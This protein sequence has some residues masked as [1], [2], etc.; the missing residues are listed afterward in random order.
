MRGLVWFGLVCECGV[1]WM[2]SV[3]TAD[4]DGG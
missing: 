1:Q 2:I 4:G 3:F